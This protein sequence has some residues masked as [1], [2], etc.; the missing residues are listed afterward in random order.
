MKRLKPEREKR[1]G[2]RSLLLLSARKECVHENEKHSNPYENRDDRLQNRAERCFVR[3][4]IRE[5]VQK[6]R[7]QGPHNDQ[8]DHCRNYKPRPMS[9]GKSTWHFSPSPCEKGTGVWSGGY[10][11][12]SAGRMRIGFRDW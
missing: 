5:S 7:K 8:H 4:V 11:S 3:C 6:R 12:I 10:L 9:D 1:S 2:F